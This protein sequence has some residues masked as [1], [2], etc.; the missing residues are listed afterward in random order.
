MKLSR[1]GIAIAAAIAASLCIFTIHAAVH[2]DALEPGGGDWPQYR[3]NNHSTWENPGIF[4]VAQAANLTP[5]WTYE[6]GVAGYGAP[7][8]VGDTVYITTAFHSSKVIA[9]DA[10]TGA[11]KWQRQ[12]PGTLRTTNCGIFNP[13]IW[14]A[15]AVVN[16][17]L[18]VGA[19]DGNVYALDAVTGATQ[20]SVAVSL[21]TVHGEFLASAPV[22]STVLN[23]L[24]IGTSAITDCE[25]PPGKIISV[26]LTT[27][28][29][30]VHEVLAPGRVGG[31]IWSSITVDEAAGIVYATTG[32]PQHAPSLDPFAQSVVAFDAQTLQALDHWQDPTY[33]SF[34]DSDFG[35]SP[36]LF[37]A[38]DGTPLVGAPNKDGW[39]FVWKRGHLSDGPLWTRNIAVNGGPDSG[40]GSIVAP[41]FANGVL[42]VAGGQT[43]A[44]EPGSVLALD[45]GTGALLWKHVPPG[46]VIAGMATVGEV[47]FVG[48]TAHGNASHTLELLDAR[49]GAVLAQ[50]PGPNALWAAPTVGHGL[51]LFTNNTGHLVAM[52][53]PDYRP[54]APDGG[55]APD[56]GVS[57]GGITDGGV[58]GDGGTASDGGVTD[59]GVS[60]GGVSD[61]GTNETVLFDDSFSRTGPLGPTWQIA[62]GGFTDD[63]A[64]AQ[65]T[66]PRSYAIA[67]V[68]PPLSATAV[69]PIGV[70]GTDYNGVLLRASPA[71]PSAEHY[72]AY[73]NHDGSLWIARRN[74]AIYTY[75]GKASLKVNPAQPHTLALTAQGTAPV[76]LR[77]SVDGTPVLSVTDSSAQRLV[78]PGRAGIFSWSGTGAAFDEF[79]V[80]TP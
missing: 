53:I 31:S 15:P 3:Q 10:A 22:V 67:R 23:K 56:A 71:N 32:N 46:Y 51:V 74:A 27:H 76:L 35:A 57:D 63:G 48:V 42:Y 17:V 7:T 5:L 73:M 39:F 61:G 24:Y 77:F 4:D 29:A 79:E 47:L 64:H 78:N 34:E 9:L 40:R 16:G 11:V 72:A 70:L 66:A 68:A 80:E 26:D 14:H 6:L 55:P 21:P 28:Q 43:P 18:Y 30:I 59:G 8:L 44:G 2:A 54:G 52:Q 36:T 69:S 50:V 1:I 38:A 62:H 58:T 45:P 37:T 75:L 65:P 13:G 60:D 12:F 19:P 33:T 20:W 49:S 41:T 25:L